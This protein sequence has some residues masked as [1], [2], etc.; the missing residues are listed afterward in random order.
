MPSKTASK[1]TNLVDNWTLDLSSFRNDKKISPCFSNQVFVLCST[2]LAQYI[3]NAFQNMLRQSHWYHTI[4][5]ASPSSPN[6]LLTHLVTSVPLF[7]ISPW[8][9][10]RINSPCLPCPCDS[11]CGKNISPF[12]HVSH[13]CLS[14]I[15]SLLLSPRPNA[16]NEWFLLSLECPASHH[17]LVV[18][19]PWPSESSGFFS[20]SESSVPTPSHLQAWCVFKDQ[21]LI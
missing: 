6:V 7:L 10:P 11:V 9:A 18:Y 16:C 3:L 17:L 1:E 4:L 21:F 12:Q 15:Q 14:F 19:K 5:V 8:M 20:A 2:L 13:S